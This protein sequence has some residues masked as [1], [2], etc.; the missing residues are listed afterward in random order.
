VLPLDY[1]IRNLGRSPSRLVMLVGGSALLVATVLTAAAFVRGMDEALRA[2]GAP[3]NVILLGAGSESAIERSE[4]AAAAPGIV[5][6]SIHGIREHAGA[7]FVSPEVHAM[8]F[9][10]PQSRGAVDVDPRPVTVRGVTPAALLVHRNVTIIAGAFPRAGHDEVMI[11]R[12][13]STRMGVDADAL[14]LGTTLEIDGRPWR[15]SGHFSADGTLAEAEIWTAMTDLME[16]TRRIGISCIVLTIDPAE[17]E[18]ED[19]A[20]FTMMRPDLELVAIRETEYYDQLAGFFAPIRVV[21]W[22]TATLIVLGG[23]LGGLNTMYAAFVAR[24][25]EL[26]TLQ[27]LGFRRR[28]IALSLVQESVVATA[29]GTLIACSVGVLFLDG[30]SVRFSQGAFGLIVDAPVLLITLATGLL[31]GALGAVPPA[32]RCLR[33]PIPYALRGH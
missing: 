25:R 20:V 21:V 33:L 15:I 27:A 16:A 22:T 28:A 2:T 29:A 13:A 26:G 5:E 19:I 11:G 17:I 14:A 10:R 1:A 6:A 18:F 31:L 7:A 8:L 4:M 12:S 23:F 24:I 9:A 30:V 32:I 3:D